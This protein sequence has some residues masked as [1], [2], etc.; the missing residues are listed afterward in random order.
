MSK[1]AI[2]DGDVLAYN[3]C[4]PRWHKKAR[5]ENDTTVVSLDDNGK[6]VPLEFSKE[7]D[8]YYLEE[9]WEN[10]KMLLNNMV[11]N[12]YCAD[13]IMAVAGN[14]NFR[15]TLYSE[16]KMNRHADPTKQNPFVPS[17]RTLAVMEELAIRAEEREADDLIRIWA[18]EA[19][20]ADIDYIICSIDKDLLCIP[21]THWR[22]HKNELVEVSELEAMRNYYKQLIIGDPSD[23]IPGVP[24]VGPKT[25]DK[26]LNCVTEEYEFQCV[27]VN[28]YLAAYDTKWKDYLLANGKLI[29]LQKHPTDYFSLNNWEIV[30]ELE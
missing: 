7:E 20:N 24:G 13:Y 15:K 3:A 2:I 27:V 17:L 29:H 21:G 8:R 22:I 19:R 23:N 6:K 16:Y 18:E 1:L 5:I 9:S 26:L 12:L 14:N 10:F 25:A 4:K 30:K 11:D 28:E